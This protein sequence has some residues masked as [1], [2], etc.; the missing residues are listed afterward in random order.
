MSRKSRQKTIVRTSGVQLSTPRQSLRWPGPSKTKTTYLDVEDRRRYSPVQVSPK[1]ISGNFARLRE[2]FPSVKIKTGLQKPY[3]VSS[4][5]GVPYK[6][7]FRQP[8]SVLICVRRRARREVLFAQNRA[9]RNGQRKR[10]LNQFSE[11]HC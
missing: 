2:K 9:G 6:F 10:V 7:A 3:E 11:V 4:L 5:Y 1:T 8:L